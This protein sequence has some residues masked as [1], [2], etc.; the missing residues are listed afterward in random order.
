MAAQASVPASAISSDVPVFG[1][2][3]RNAVAAGAIAVIVIAAALAL[4]LVWAANSGA[5]RTHPLQLAANAPAKEPAQPAAQSGPLPHMRLEGQYAGPL[6]DTVIQRW[7]D[8]VDGTVCYLYLPV[9]VRHSP[10][11]QTGLVQYGANTI[12]SISCSPPR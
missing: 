5:P 6:K 9:I 4:G 3:S 2:L 1:A 8:P 10:P 7:R 11:T 12:G